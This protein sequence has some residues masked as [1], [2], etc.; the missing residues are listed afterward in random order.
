MLQTILRKNT[1]T[2]QVTSRDVLNAVNS[3]LICDVKTMDFYNLIG[4]RQGYDDVTA[5]VIS[6]LAKYEIVIS[7]LVK[8][9][10]LDGIKTISQ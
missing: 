9:F 2:V 10:T 7:S 8:Y 1:S 5:K 3:R 6:S 4:C